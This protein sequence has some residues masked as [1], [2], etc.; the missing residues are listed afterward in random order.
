M[1][2]PVALVVED[3]PLIAMDIA[4]TIEDA[5]WRVL[6]PAASVARALPLLESAKPDIAFVDVHLNGETSAPIVTRLRELGAPI[7]LATAYPN[8]QVMG[9]EFASLPI[10]VKPF[11]HAVLR[12]IVD[13]QRGVSYQIDAGRRIVF[14][15]GRGA[16]RVDDI[17]DMQRRL[18]ADPD[19]DPTY[20]MLADYRAAISIQIQ[21]DRVHEV[22]AN[23]PFAASSRRAF[24]V[25]GVRN[26]EI[27]RQFQALN[28]V[29]GTHGKVAVFYDFDSANRWLG[30]T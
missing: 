7:V 29:S 30:E 16:L 20:R 24:V 2:Q 22:A 15:Y 12:M 27:V 11:D 13:R 1:D 23:A 21:M 6:G 17:L 25:R 5:G 8:P 18:R 10:L 26:Y 14:L 28:D 19:F 9:A 4:L 3:E